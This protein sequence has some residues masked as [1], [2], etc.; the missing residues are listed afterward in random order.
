MNEAHVVKATKARVLS[1]GQPLSELVVELELALAQSDFAVY[2]MSFT[3]A[4]DLSK[5][6]RSAIEGHGAGPNPKG[7]R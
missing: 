5:Q 6:I 2:R 3:T 1:E 4:S 7:P